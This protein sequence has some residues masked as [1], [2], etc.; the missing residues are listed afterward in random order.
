[1]GTVRKKANINAT[2]EKKSMITYIKMT[3]GSGEV[4]LFCNCS[5]SGGRSRR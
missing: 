2:S 5:Y 4:D 1:M 3:L